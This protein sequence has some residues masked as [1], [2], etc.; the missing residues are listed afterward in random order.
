MTNRQLAQ[1]TLTDA[2]DYIKV[3]LSGIDEIVDKF[4]AGREDLALGM[5][6]DLIG[7][8]QW[9]IEVVDL[10]KPLTEGYQVEFTGRESLDGVM[11]EMTNAFENRDYVLIGD[12]LNFE[13]KPIL[14]QWAVVLHQLCIRFE[15]T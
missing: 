9:L 4:L 3:L 15:T 12:L 11:S 7:G 14:G 10:T 8:L 13:L 2:N 6:T 5:M 1:E